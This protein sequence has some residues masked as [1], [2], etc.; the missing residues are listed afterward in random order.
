MNKLVLFLF[1]MI[2][3]FSSIAQ[4][5]STDSSVK[6]FDMGKSIKFCDTEY[7]FAWSTLIPMIFII[8]KNIFPMGK[9]STITLKCLP[10]V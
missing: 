6:Y 3:S 5:N 4:N 2:A 7:K 10:L 8:C 1:V 9:L